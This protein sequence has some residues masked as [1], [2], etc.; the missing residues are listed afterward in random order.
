MDPRKPR[1][2]KLFSISITVF[3]SVVQIVISSEVQL[4]TSL[5][6]CQT[7]KVLLKEFRGLAV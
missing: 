2:G 4:S 7:C 3:G 6:V 1:L 5:Q